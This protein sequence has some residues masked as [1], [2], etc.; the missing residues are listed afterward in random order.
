MTGTPSAPPAVPPPTD[1]EIV[2][3]RL[4]DAPRALVFD[5]W[6]DA[7]HISAW[8][9]P[10]GFTTT[11]HEM[12]V[13]PGGVWRFVMHGPDGVDYRNRVVYTEVARP[14]RLVYAHRGEGVDDHGE[15]HVTVTFTE[16]DGR[17]RVVLRMQAASV[18]EC[19]RMKAFGAIEGGHQTLERLG[20]YLAAR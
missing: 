16:E 17:T 11:T 19:E 18:A 2:V 5:A 13:R 14:E 9:G 8:W 4:L 20:E 15:F 1:R 7:A 6:T 10:R 12:N 3:T